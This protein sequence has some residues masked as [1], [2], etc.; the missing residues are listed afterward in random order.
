MFADVW[1]PKASIRH[2]SHIHESNILL[3]DAIIIAVLAARS[4][5]LS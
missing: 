3:I 5:G 4:M 2:E 1:L